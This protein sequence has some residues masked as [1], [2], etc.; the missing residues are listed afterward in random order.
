MDEVESGKQAARHIWSHWGKPSYIQPDDPMT[1]EFADGALLEFE[2][3]QE[4]APGIMHVM[5]DGAH[6][7][8]QQLNLDDY[9]GV[10]EV[11]QNADDLMASEVVVAIVREPE[12]HELLIV[13]NG[14]PVAVQHVLAMTYAF[15]STKVEDSRQKGKFGVGLKTLGRIADRMEVHSNTYSFAIENQRIKQIPPCAPITGIYQTGTRS[16]LLRLRLFNIFDPEEFV[17]WFSSLDAS[18]LLFLDS[19]A[20][21]R[22][23][24]EELPPIEHILDK[25]PEITKR[26]TH[27]DKHVTVITSC[28]CRDRA[29]GSEWT[30][31]HVEVDVPKRVSRSHKKTG[32]KTR[33]GLA[34]AANHGK[35]EIYAGLPTYIKSSLPFSIDAQF[36]PDTSREALL[37]TAWNKWLIGEMAEFLASLVTG[38]L[39]DDP[40]RAWEMIPL[41]AE[42]K[43]E[44]APLEASVREALQGALDKIKNISRIT[45]SGHDELLT[46]IS[47]EVKELEGLLDDADYPLLSEGKYGLPLQARDAK[48]RWRIIL[49]EL[50]CC[51]EITVADAF[52]LFSNDAACA[53]KEPE[54]YVEFLS[55]AVASSTY[56]PVFTFPCLLLESGSRMEAQ[57]SGSR[58]VMLVRENHLHTLSHFTLSH[59]LHP[60]YFRNQE[61]WQVLADFF[62]NRTN[63]ADHANPLDLLTSFANRH[64]KAPVA[65]TD[66]ELA[67]IKS[68]FDSCYLDANG[69]GNRL[70]SSILL[71]AYRWERGKKVRSKARISECY[72]PTGIVKDK[73]SQWFVA[74]GKTPD[75][76]WISSRYSQL[77]RGYKKS[78]NGASDE[79][80]RKAPGSGRFFR[81]LGAEIAPRIVEFAE[82]R[83]LPSPLPRLQREAIGKLNTSP[84]HLEDDYL[85]RDLDAVIANICNSKKK[86]ER[87]DRGI[88]L[89][90]AIAFSWEHLYAGMEECSTTYHYYSWKYSG[91][92]PS[93][94][95]ARLAE[96]D[97]L[98]NMKNTPKAPIDLVIRTSA[99]RAVYGDAPNLFAAGLDEDHCETAF[100]MA[101]RMESNP[102]A[103]GIIEQIQRMR[104]GEDSFAILRLQQLYAALAEI[105]KRLK[106][107]A[108]VPSSPFDDITVGMLRSRFGSD[109]VNGL[110]YVDGV[111][112][113]PGKVLWGRNIFHGHRLFVTTTKKLDPLWRALGLRQPGFEDCLSVLRELAKQPLQR[114]DEATLIDTYRHV[115]AKLGSL[116][117]AEKRRLGE[118]PLWCHD[119]W[120]RERPIFLANNEEIAKNLADAI[121]MWTPPCSFISMTSLLDALRV[122]VIDSREFTLHGVTPIGAV[123]GEQER[124]RFMRTVAALEE[125]FARIDDQIYRSI[126]VEWETLKQAPLYICE[127]LAMSW[128]YPGLPAVKSDIRAHVTNNPLG[129]YFRSIDDIGEKRAGGKVVAECFLP[130][131]CREQ[132]AVTWVWKWQEAVRIQSPELSLAKDPEDDQQDQV[133]EAMKKSKGRTSQYERG[134]QNEKKTSPAEVTRVER[135]LK[136]FALLGTASIQSVNGGAEPG[137]FKEPASRGLKKQLPPAPAAGTPPPGGSSGTQ[138]VI[139][140]SSEELE[141]KALRCLDHVLKHGKLGE[142]KDFRKLRGI[143]ADAVLDLKKFFEI[144]A[145]AREMPDR[146]ELTLNE[147]D[148]ARLSTDSFYLVVVS[149]LEEGYETVVNIYKNPLRTLDWYP[150]R[151]LVVSGLNTKKGVQVKLEVDA[152]N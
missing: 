111:W 121:P 14:E 1:R 8:A 100:P 42:M 36:D 34:L 98:M 126:Q 136:D 68:L 38:M 51:R 149:G 25:D 40:Q 69:L 119:K 78:T 76:T 65:L 139:K 72:L 132:V 108:A 104:D 55:A 83:Y 37:P 84:S 46:D 3:L 113:M 135:K 29:S 53:R 50:G 94:W 117:S 60:V 13:H 85:S 52:N 99:T 110:L 129:F 21:F 56:A 115:N 144:K 97:W 79:S 109:G 10:M 82:R 107:A 152:N 90:E 30:R 96:A 27:D 7:G 92:I 120:V 71:D 6:K 4:E 93:T 141:E 11:L 148:R 118:L 103:S 142:L 116:S 39:A 48:G 128:S 87:K 88:A 70:G 147:L 138:T 146:V 101:M 124:P 58:T 24:P 74:A 64:E 114:C 145:S 73:A 134:G 105:A 67:G 130:E 41:A 23:F 54:W 150:S 151:S 112:T 95:I 33:L 137:G 19:V 127:H 66:Q 16:T 20:A 15:I 26:T 61:R 89:F 81:S 102:R 91:R 18:I 49:K 9:H 35:N 28:R 125:Y 75:I 77:L 63:Y 122:K 31:F 57:Q 44:N 62:R 123:V 59:T 86:G 131:T 17:D 22:F 140:Y 43:F 32:D 106:G 143:G 47:F 5:A 12:Y 45:I 80:T 133:L 2:R